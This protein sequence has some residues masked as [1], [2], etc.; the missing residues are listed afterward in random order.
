MAPEIVTAVRNPFRAAGPPAAVRGRS[1]NGQG[2]PTNDRSLLWAAEAGQRTQPRSRLGSARAPAAG[3]L[4]AGPGCP[5]EMGGRIVAAFLPGL[6]ASMGIS[7]S[8]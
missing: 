1:E 2:F 4:T 8:I 5:P 3:I 7:R 6:E